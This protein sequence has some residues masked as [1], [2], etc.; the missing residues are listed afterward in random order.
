MS[1]IFTERMLE[2]NVSDFLMWWTKIYTINPFCI[3]YFG[4]FDQI[5]EAQN[6]RFGYVQDLEDEDSKI[7]YIKYLRLNP[8]NLTVEYKN[9]SRVRWLHELMQD[10]LMLK[11]AYEPEVL[12]SI[13]A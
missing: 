6:S 8:Q 13:Q 9:L 1:L 12:R 4:P 3:Y 5:E 7:V 10:N 11:V 2:D